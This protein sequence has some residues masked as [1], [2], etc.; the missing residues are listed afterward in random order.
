MRKSEGALG[1][2]HANRTEWAGSNG[3]P[4][5]AVLQAAQT[6]GF[7]SRAS[8]AQAVEF[9]HQS[10]CS[11]HPGRVVFPGRPSSIVQETP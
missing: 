8:G 11:G 9:D 3:L 7:D 5:S 10:G 6:A 2:V 1:D 4:G